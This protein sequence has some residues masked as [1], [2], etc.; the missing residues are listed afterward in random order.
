MSERIIVE[1]TLG[2][3][4][5]KG[6]KVLILLYGRLVLLFGRLVLLFGRLDVIHA[7]EMNKAKKLCA[8]LV[9]L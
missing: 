1:F 9:M 8:I 6:I 7:D 5:P 2:I 4:P 3:Y